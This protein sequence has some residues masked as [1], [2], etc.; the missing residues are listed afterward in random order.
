VLVDWREGLRDGRGL[1]SRLHGHV[2][3]AAGV[4]LRGESRHTAKLLPRYY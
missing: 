2:G 4:S 1:C 3:D